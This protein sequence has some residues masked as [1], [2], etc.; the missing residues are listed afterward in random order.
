MSWFYIACGNEH[1][2]CCGFGFFVKNIWVTN[3]KSGA[4]LGT[5]THRFVFWTGYLAVDAG[6][7]Q[8]YDMPR[9]KAP[10]TLERVVFFKVFF[11][12]LS[13]TATA[14]FVLDGSFLVIFKS[15]IAMLTYKNY[16]QGI[17]LCTCPGWKKGRIVFSITYWGLW[18]ILVM[19]Y[20]RDKTVDSWRK[21]VSDSGI[22]R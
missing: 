8:Y 19:I 16:M 14:W 7:C 9:D 10:V 18:G 15:A 20:V 4:K 3:G 13:C 22:Y 17:S 21:F 5:E 6:A 2:L 12:C 11:L 1:K